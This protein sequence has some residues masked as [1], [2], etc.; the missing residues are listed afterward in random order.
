MIKACKKCRVQFEI[1]DE[2]LQFYN[3]VSPVFNGKRYDIPT[4]TLCPDCRQQRR[5]AQC[6]EINLYPGECGMCKKKTPTDHVPHINQPIYC[7]ECWHNDKW[8]ARSYGQ[9]F[10]F[11][12]LFF[13]QLYD[14]RKTVP[15]LALNSQGTC[16]NSDYIHYAGWSKNSYL[17]M[18]ADFCENCYYGYGFKKNLYCVDGFYNLHC[19]L[20]YDCVDIYKCYGLTCC[21]D[22][23]RCASGAFLRDCLGCNDCFLCVGLRNARF[24]FENQQLTKE[25]YKERM[26]NVD[27][28]SYKRY[29]TYKAQLN[30][31]AKKHTFKEYHGT[32]LQNCF[33]DYLKNCKDLKYSFDCEDVE[34]GKYCYQIVLGG[35]S[36]YDVY[37]FGTNFQLGYECIICG[38]NSYHIMFSDNSMMDSSDLFYCWYMEGSKNCFGCTG[39]N[40][41]SYCVLNKQYT[42]KE[43]EKL[44]P[45]IIEHMRKTGEWGEFWP[46]RISLHGYNKTTAQMY[47]PLS[48]EETLKQGF[49][50][51]DYETPPPQF[52][53][54]IKAKDL[55][56]NIEK[57]GDDILDAAIECE[58]TKKLFK[59]TA[60]ELQFYRRVHLPL[61]RRDWIQRH[62]DRFQ[63]RNPR[64]FWKRKCDKCGNEI[65]TTYSSDRPEIVYCEKCYMETVYN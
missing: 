44:V 2:D 8:D 51:E 37:Q 49:K 61:P 1:T 29:Q 30:E 38:E 15:A 60:P 11:N 25:E 6:N 7:R 23:T 46:A 31:M 14:L 52:N 36:L 9:D 10:D 57:V 39:M 27:F 18:H 55:P 58:V 16:V 17:I 54:I 3:S 59:I 24:C 64:K 33:G 45:K 4:P 12:R 20:C 21:Q 50:W 5:L 63:Q 56:D 40:H 62:I 13:D 53:K 48:R 28:G 43:Y 41:A 34:T 42:K 47:Y 32:N 65:M 26:K 19:E 22:C 35:K